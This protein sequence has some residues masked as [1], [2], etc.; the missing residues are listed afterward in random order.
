MAIEIRKQNN[1][2]TQSLIRRFTKAVRDSGI[3]YTARKK[4]FRER[5]KSDTLKRRSALRREQIRKLL[6]L[7]EKWGGKL[8]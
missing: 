7:K 5:P 8:V 6:E 1:E 4:M 2:T 3:L